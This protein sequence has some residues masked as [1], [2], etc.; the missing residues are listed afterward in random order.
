MPSAE[1]IVLEV[2][3]YT[4]PRLRT[5]RNLCVAAGVLAIL[6]GP[7]AGGVALVALLVVGVVLLVVAFGV[8]I[9]ARAARD[10]RLVV[11][12]E[13]I[14]WDAG[15]ATWRATWSELSDVGLVVLR[16][17]RRGRTTDEPGGERVIR[18]LMAFRS[19]DPDAGRP[20]LR[21]IRTTGEPA[22]WTHRMPIASRGDWAGRL[23][24]GLARYGQ[25]RYAGM[26]VRDALGREEGAA[27]D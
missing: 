3:S 12:R 24:A 27:P 6:A 13:G 16:S 15:D 23:D 25:G 21:R 19:D 10:S 8:S 9:A 7:V 26:T 17:R 20:P 2:G 14:T 18:V 1:P 22:P 4:G 5:A 11:D